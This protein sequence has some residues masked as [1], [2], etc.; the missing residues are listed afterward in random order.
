MKT[1]ERGIGLIK[2][3]EGLMLVAYKCPAGV[4]T[5][6]YGHTK[7]VAKGQRISRE[8]ADKLLS[9]DL[10][11]IEQNIDKMGLKIN[12]NQFDALVS[13]AFNVGINALRGSTLL[14]KIRLN[15]N[16]TT[17]RDEFMRWVKA[18]GGKRLPG[19]ER[20]RR[21]ESELYFN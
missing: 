10:T 12:Q 4:W 15:A 11:P 8:E 7:D 17:I 1:S 16:D 21:E 3:Y 6:G 5:I 2:K 13:F 18:G 20:R 14:K 9:D 19:L